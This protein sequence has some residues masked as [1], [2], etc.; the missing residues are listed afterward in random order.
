MKEL[1]DRSE[2]PKTTIHHYMREDL[3]P[4]ARKTAPNAALYGEE[5]LERL[6]LI[7]RLRD[8]AQL[9][10]PEIRRVIAHLEEGFDEG[11]S[12]RLVRERVEPPGNGRDEPNPDFT[13]ELADAGLVS[14]ADP[15]AMS[16]GDLLVSRACE[17]VCSDRGV[18][19][20]DLA[21]LVDLI[22]EVGNYSATLVDVGEARR[23]P[24]AAGRSEDLRGDL[25]RLCDALLWRA[26]H[27]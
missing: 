8:D 17:T 13:E 6:R 27:G 22:R 21:P 7:T 19:P 5:H 14:A 10:I 3:L 9:S 26:F 4:P 23:G 18:E 11:A 12:V 2:L 1:A 24:E 16:A 25:A 20:A 15:E